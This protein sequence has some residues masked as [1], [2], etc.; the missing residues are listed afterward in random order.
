[1]RLMKIV[2]GRKKLDDYTLVDPCAIDALTVRR[3]NSHHGH[4]YYVKI[5]LKD[6]N[7]IKVYLT[8]SKKEC[9]KYIKAL[10]KELKEL[11][12]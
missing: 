3:N 5:I 7:S 9:Y 11:S 2:T 4:A 10:G 8:K 12:D 6:G 1:M